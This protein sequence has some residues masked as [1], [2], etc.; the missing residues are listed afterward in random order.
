MKKILVILAIALFSISA[1][2]DSKSGTGDKE[3]LKNNLKKTIAS[4]SEGSQVGV[5][6]SEI[7]EYVDCYVD[8]IYDK[9]DKDTLEKLSKVTST[10]ESKELDKELSEKEKDIILK[11]SIDCTPKFTK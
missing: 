1:C 3:S 2:S 4:V 8:A 7:N 6:D 10:A 11:A 9:L 5:K